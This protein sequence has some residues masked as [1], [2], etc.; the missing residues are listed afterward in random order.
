MDGC[1][2]RNCIHIYSSTNRIS[3]RSV[4]FKTAV[5]DRIDFMEN[6]LLPVIRKR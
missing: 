5:H 6:I 4:Y 2:S 3:A 1:S